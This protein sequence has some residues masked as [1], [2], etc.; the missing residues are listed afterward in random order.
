MTML[1]KTVPAGQLPPAWQHELGLGP[2][3]PVRVAIEAMPWTR[4]PEEVARLLGLLDKLEPVDAGGEVTAFIRSERER[5][6]TRGG[7]GN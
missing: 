2:D 3:A 6:D 1:I 7:N 5:L 4:A